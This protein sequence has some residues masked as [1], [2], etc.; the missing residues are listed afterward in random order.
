[1]EKRV[2]ITKLIV[3][4]IAF[5]DDGENLVEIEVEPLEVPADQINEFVA[6]GLRESL[7]SLIESFSQ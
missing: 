2:R 3:V 6:N 4:P 7:D 5:I 1:M